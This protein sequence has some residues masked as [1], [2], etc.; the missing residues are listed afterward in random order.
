MGGKWGGKWGGS[1][2]RWVFVKSGS[3]A[4]R[5]GGAPREAREAKGN[6]ECKVYVGQLSYKTNWHALKEFFEENSMTVVF[7]KVM[8][9]DAPNGKTGAWSKGFGV[10]EFSTREEAKQAIATLDGAELDGRAIKID[11]WSA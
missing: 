1:G 4:A 8:R 9:E 7:A 6:P 11:K 10:V 3:E 5:S 2:G